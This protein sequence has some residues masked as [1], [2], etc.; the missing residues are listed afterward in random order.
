M[1]LASRRPWE[2]L[3][4]GVPARW[5]R[6]QFRPDYG[7]AFALS[8]NGKFFAYDNGGST[9]PYGRRLARIQAGIP[10]YLRSAMAVIRNLWRSARMASA[11]LSEM[12]EQ[13]MYIPQLKEFRRNKI[14]IS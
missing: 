13:F 7:L 6:R 14:S 9:V 4:C 2:R 11:S 5:G 1:V 8:S 10:S 12:A 3:S